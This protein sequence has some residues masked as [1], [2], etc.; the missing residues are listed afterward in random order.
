MLTGVAQKCIKSYIIN[1][2]YFSLQC[3]SVL[4]MRLFKLDIEVGENSTHST[5]SCKMWNS[6]GFV[7]RNG[8]CFAFFRSLDCLC[9]ELNH[10]STINYLVRYARE[11]LKMLSREFKQRKD[12]ASE[13]TVT[14]G[15]KPATTLPASSAS[16]VPTVSTS[17][18]KGT[19][20]AQ[21]DQQCQKQNEVYF[22][23]I[24]WD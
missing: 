16:S 3:Q 17:T 20:S 12:N 22:T 4:H 1:D 5:L 7:R 21:Q 23:S 13:T 11:G 14:V 6:A 9:G 15:A 19:N 10:Y 8:P 24:N 2:C 18:M